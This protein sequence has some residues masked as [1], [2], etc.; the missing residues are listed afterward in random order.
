MTYF[1]TWAAEVL[2]SR[3]VCY[4]EWQPK[5]LPGVHKALGIQMIS[6]SCYN[7]CDW[8]I[9][10]PKQTNFHNIKDSDFRFKAYYA[11]TLL[12][13][14]YTLEW[15]QENMSYS[16]FPVNHRN[17]RQLQVSRRSCMQNTVDEAVL[18]VCVVIRLHLISSLKKCGARRHVS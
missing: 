3:N 11:D 8:S 14:D 12:S 4:V 6:R 7:K 10:N 13:G 15:W 5:D 17:T 1:L 9:L 18:C 16:L 2:Y